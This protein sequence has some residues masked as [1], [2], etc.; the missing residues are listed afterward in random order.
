[1]IS[2]E[3]LLALEK[4]SMA[5]PARTLQAEDL[6]MLVELLSEKNDKLRYPAFLLL[7]ER[8]YAEPD[9]YTYWDTFRDK[10]RSDNSYQRSIGLMLLAVNTRWDDSGRME[11][12]IEDYLKLLEDEKPITIRQ[13][14]Q[15]LSYILPYQPRLKAVIA[16][17]LMALELTEIKDTMRKL[18]CMD[19]LNILALIRETGKDEEIENYILNALKGDL[20]DKKSK[21][22][23]EE[24]CKLKLF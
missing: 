17:R 16:K 1:M 9:V 10:L 22:Q 24:L 12:T 20:L 23:I 3:W 14:I 8:S 21:K 6:E 5:G 18:V 15:Y 13:C 11:A 2:K 7:Q 19:I 4:E